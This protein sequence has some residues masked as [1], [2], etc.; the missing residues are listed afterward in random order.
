MTAFRAEP[1]TLGADGTGRHLLG[2]P[3]RPGA[4]LSIEDRSH[5]HAFRVDLRTRRCGGARRPLSMLTRSWGC[6]ACWRAPS[7]RFCR[8]CGPTLPRASRRGPLPTAVVRPAEADAGA[9]FGGAAR[10]GGLR[11]AR[12]RKLHTRR[13]PEDADVAGPVRR[14]RIRTRGGDALG[15]R[16]P[17]APGGKRPGGAVQPYVRAMNPLSESLRLHAKEPTRLRTSHASRSRCSSPVVGPVP[18]SP[19]PWPESP[20]KPPELARNLKRDQTPT[21]EPNTQ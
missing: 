14:R 4:G 6:G 11:D 19:P 17:A 8:V 1:E 7:Q 2:H 13:G 9:D 21:H 12:A 18:G 16:Q 3:H 10:S 15:V 20:P 5:H